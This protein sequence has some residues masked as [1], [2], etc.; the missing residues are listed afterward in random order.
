MKLFDALKRVTDSFREGVGHVLGRPSAPLATSLEELEELL[1]VSDVS[2]ETTR[3]L[4]ANIGKRARKGEPLAEAFQNTVTSLLDIPTPNLF[5]Q[6]EPF[7][8]LLVGTNGGG[9]TTSAAKLARFLQLRGKRV[10][11]CAADTFRAAGGLQLEEWGRRLNL[12]VESDE[13]GT[14]ASALIYRSVERFHSEKFDVL[15]VDTA[16]RVASKENL[17]KELEKNVRTIKKLVPEEP[18]E[19]FMVL[20]A[21]IGQNAIVQAKEF[22]R[23]SGLTGIV[24]TKMDGTAKGGTVLTI[25]EQFKLPVKFVGVGEGTEDLYPFSPQE[26]GRL[27]FGP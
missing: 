18:R 26:Y 2:Y 6:D 15:L 27:L 24:L 20:D 10:L 3:T 16:G 1:I 4:I 5:L 25:A 13:K 7:I 17:M 14:A 8:A 22:L 12:P 11:L 21:T 9:K 19:V 23:F